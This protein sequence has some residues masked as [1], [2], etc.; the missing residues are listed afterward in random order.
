[1]GS[2]EIFLNQIVARAILVANPCAVLHLADLRIGV[3]ALWLS[4][5]G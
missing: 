2:F 3:L 5:V 1:M 4:H